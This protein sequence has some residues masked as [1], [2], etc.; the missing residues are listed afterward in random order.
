MIRQH[1][2]RTRSAAA[3]ENETELK[4]R[5]T[6]LRENFPPTAIELLHSS[7]ALICC[8]KGAAAGDRYST[9]LMNSVNH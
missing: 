1:V 3:S 6:K 7:V 4:T 5:L 9:S 2:Q 8:T